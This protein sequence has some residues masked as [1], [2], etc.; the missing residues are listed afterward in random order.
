MDFGWVKSIFQAKRQNSLDI[1]Q[2]A[3][4]VEA[5]RENMLFQGNGANTRQDRGAMHRVP[6]GPTQN[7]YF[8]TNTIERSQAFLE[9]FNTYWEAQKMVTIPVDDALR[10]RAEIK[11]ISDGDAKDLWKA[12]DDRDLD[13]QN[14]RALVQER[15]FGGCLAFGVFKTSSPSMDWLAEPLRL[16][17]IQKGDF[18]A[19]NVFDVTMVGQEAERYNPFSPDFDRPPRYRVNGHPVDSS[20][21]ILL[22]GSPVVN[23]FSQSTLERNRVGNFGFGE[24]VLVKLYETIKRATGA[25]NGAYHLINLSSCLIIM[26][27]HLRSMKASNAGAQEALDN[28]AEDFSIYRATVVDGKEVKISQHAASFG[29]VPELMMMY[30]QFLSAAGDIPAARYLSQAP[31]GLNTTGESDLQNYNSMVRANVQM[32]KLKPLQ[33]REFDWIGCSLWGFDGWMRRRENLEIDYPPLWNETAK[34]KAD[35]MAIYSAG[36]GSLISN[37]TISGDAAVK[38]LVAQGFFMTE[39][40]AMDA[41][42]GDPR[43]EE[44]PLDPKASIAELAKKGIP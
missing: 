17:D 14:R 22:D 39:M 13:K 32:G 36:L 19:L 16:H 44:S 28:L 37:G 40:E 31:G 21:L 11:G 12:Y 5:K 10:Y 24:S 4:A 15:L 1:A 29:A 18:E 3:P 8:L 23:R 25:Q 20:R 2:A 35:R 33:L 7:P 34:E 43:T 41:L 38:E 26:A 30:M 27:E 42:M 9:M 6:P